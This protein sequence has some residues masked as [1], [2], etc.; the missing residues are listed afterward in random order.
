MI[1]QIEKEKGKAQDA[2]VA[3]VGGASLF[4]KLFLISSLLSSVPG[5]YHPHGAGAQ[6]SE[7]AEP[8]L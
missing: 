7:A 1:W 6:G 5:K 4:T 3:R 2:K 8:A